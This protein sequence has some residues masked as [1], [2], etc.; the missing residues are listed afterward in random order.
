MENICYIGQKIYDLR[1]ER[2][3]QQGELAKALGLHQSVLNRIEKG[4]RPARDMEI[5]AVARYFSVSADFL[6]GINN[7][8]SSSKAD[9]YNLQNNIHSVQ[10]FLNITN[11]G[12]NISQTNTPNS[13]TSVPSNNEVYS[14]QEQ[15]I[16]KKYRSLDDR[17]K[18]TVEDTIER[19]FSYVK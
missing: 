6:L 3:V 5:I 10:N 15:D 16:I 18:H 2:D 14:T 12:E 13:V 7:K 11:H 8:L 17:G 4:T 1:I 9:N 19:E